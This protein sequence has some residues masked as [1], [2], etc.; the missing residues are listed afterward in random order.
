MVAHVDV[1]ILA[2]LLV[3]HCCRCVHEV[4]EMVDRILPVMR[5]GV[6]HFLIF[7]VDFG[8]DVQLQPDEL[9]IV[10]VLGEEDGSFVDDWLH[11]TGLLVLVLRNWSCFE[12]GLVF[13]AEQLVKREVIPLALRGTI[14]CCLASCAFIRLVL[15]TDCAFC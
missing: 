15:A 4:R 12:E 11:V 13:A 10:G 2:I 9:G 14:C 6:L 1:Q 3:W 5:L 7:R 8:A